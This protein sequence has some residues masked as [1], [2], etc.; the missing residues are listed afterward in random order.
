MRIIR[1][2]PMQAKSGFKVTWHHYALTAITSYLVGL[3]SF[4]PL[5]EDY[6]QK[7]RLEAKA[8]SKPEKQ[9]V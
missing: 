4:Q 6:F 2:A 8:S 1:A 9:E 7:Q 5:Y 3:Y